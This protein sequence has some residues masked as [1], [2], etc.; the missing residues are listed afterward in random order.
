MA[1]AFK[2]RL[3]HKTNIATINQPLIATKARINLAIFLTFCATQI[4]AGGKRIH[5]SPRFEG[6]SLVFVN[7]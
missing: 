7:C 1:G 6:G 2:P 4:D 3:A 5:V